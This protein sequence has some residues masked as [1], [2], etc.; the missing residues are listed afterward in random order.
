MPLDCDDIPKFQVGDTVDLGEGDTGVIVSYK[1]YTRDHSDNYLVQVG[2]DIR[3]WFYGPP[4]FYMHDDDPRIGNL[5]D[6]MWWY[7]ADGKHPGF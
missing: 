2:D 1:G 5:P 7:A 6:F 4:N 3:D